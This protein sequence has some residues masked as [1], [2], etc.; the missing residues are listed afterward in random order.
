MKLFLIENAYEYEQD[1]KNQRDDN[2]P[3]DGI[4]YLDF[5][6]HNITYSSF[7]NCN[8]ISLFYQNT[9]RMTMKNK[10]FVV[11]K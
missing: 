10:Q 2:T 1:C 4:L 11:K 6:L 3:V 8:Y 9:D 5:F 7:Y